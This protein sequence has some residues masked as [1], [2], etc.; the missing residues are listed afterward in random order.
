MEFTL[1]FLFGV[2]YG[3]PNGFHPRGL[4]YGSFGGFRVE[5]RLLWLGS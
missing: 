3:S 5:D 2:A 4:S 1:G